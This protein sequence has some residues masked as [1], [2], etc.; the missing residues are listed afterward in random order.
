MFRTLRRLSLSHTSQRKRFFKT[1]VDI[2]SFQHDNTLMRKDDRSIKTFVFSDRPIQSRQEDLLGRSRAAEAFTNLLMA[3]RDESSLCALINGEWGAGKTSLLNLVKENLKSRIPPII[4]GAETCPVLIDFSPWNAKDTDGVITQ[5]FSTLSSHFREGRVRSFIEKALDS[6]AFHAA[7]LIM[8]IASKFS[9][10][11]KTLNSVVSSMKKYGQTY[12]ENGTKELAELKEEINRKLEG[13]PFRFIVFIDDLDRLNDDEIRCVI[14]LIKAVCNF[15][16]IT[17]VVAFDKNLVAQALD[18]ENK[19]CNGKEYL[20]KVIQIEYDLPTPKG[21]DIVSFATDQTKELLDRQGYPVSDLRFK[22]LLSL[23]LFSKIK[24]LR[25]AKRFLN[26]LLEYLIEFGGQIDTLDLAVLAYCRSVNDKST[27]LIASYRSLLHKM[28]SYSLSKDSLSALFDDWAKLD[29]DNE[30]RLLRELFCLDDSGGSA[31]PIRKRR[32]CN[33]EL[34][35]LFLDHDDAIVEFPF[36]SVESYLERDDEHGILTL[37]NGFNDEQYAK[38]IAFLEEMNLSDQSKMQVALNSIIKNERNNSYSTGELNLAES[39]ISYILENKSQEEIVRLLTSWIDESNRLLLMFEIVLD[40]KKGF[41]YESRP[42]KIV[43]EE[44]S[45][46]GTITDALL[47]AILR[48]DNAFQYANERVLKYVVNMR[49]KEMKTA[50]AEYNISQLMRIMA[51]G[52]YIGSYASGSEH[53]LL[54]YPNEHMKGIVDWEA[55]IE[56]FNRLDP[57]GCDQRDYQRVITYRMLAD[58]WEALDRHDGGYTSSQ[59]SKYC[60]EKGIDYVASDLY[61]RP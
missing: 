23:G 20:E 1:A 46:K 26:Q 10:A 39:Y 4:S 16:N 18:R 13:S 45:I 54:Y 38:Y 53:G 48:D 24:T 58:N 2:L 57:L 56:S 22:S 50:L 15:T 11:F 41:S 37:C 6:P 30:G 28:N 33:K 12:L 61:E 3:K 51:A 29:I 7:E 35:D 5:F 47:R 27:S 40:A 14:Q 34:L 31:E 42:L 44:E 17:Y 49:P 9:S 21:S 59:I 60:K 36:D 8:G 19:G 25:R 55:F 32:V 43:V 52:V